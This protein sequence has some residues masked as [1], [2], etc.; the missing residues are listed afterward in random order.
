MQDIIKK[1]IEIDKMAQKLT[2]EAFE[3]K[4]EAEISIENDKKLLREQY[5]QKARK[6]ITL[7]TETEQTFLKQ[8]LEEIEKKHDEIEARLKSIDAENRKKWVN[9]L[10][11]RVIGE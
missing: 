8:S 10:Y 5:I 3:L 7:N 4:K 6:R 11:S 2:D 1:I 9:D